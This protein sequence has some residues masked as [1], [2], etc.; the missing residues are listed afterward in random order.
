MR[1]LVK[2]G[3]K[4]AI[5]TTP[6]HFGTGQCPSSLPRHRKSHRLQDL[7]STEHADIGVGVLSGILYRT[8]CIKVARLIEQRSRGRGGQ[9]WVVNFYKTVF[10]KKRGFYSY[11]KAEKARKWKDESVIEEYEK[12][13]RENRYLVQSRNRLLHLYDLVSFRPI[14]RTDPPST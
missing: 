10:E 9:A 7:S 13:K 14:P 5:R 4:A 8:Q 1:S 2:A 12:E 11:T 3:L 6:N